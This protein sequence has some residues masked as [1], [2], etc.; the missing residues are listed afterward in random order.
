MV[1]V[2]VGRAVSGW[3]PWAVCQTDSW[4]TS[5]PPVLQPLPQFP[6]TPVPPALA[7]D[8]WLWMHFPFGL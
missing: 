6:L 3:A 2:V 7:G 1:V 4:R 8:L 5:P